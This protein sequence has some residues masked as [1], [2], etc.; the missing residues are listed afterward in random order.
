MNTLK[1]VGITLPLNLVFV[2]LVAESKLFVIGCIIITFIQIALIA[3]VDI[4]HYGNKV[5]F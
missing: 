2:F 1:I 5:G 3:Y 4:Y